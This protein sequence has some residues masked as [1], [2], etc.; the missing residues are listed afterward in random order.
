MAFEAQHE[1]L[2]NYLCANT[3]FSKLCLTRKWPFSGYSNMNSRMI[4]FDVECSAL[5]IAQIAKPGF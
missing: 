4:I 2:D 1:A 3:T 5:K